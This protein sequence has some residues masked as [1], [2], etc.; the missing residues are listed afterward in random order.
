MR[1]SLVPTSMLTIEEIEKASALLGAQACNERNQGVAV[2]LIVVLGA[3]GS[4]TAGLRRLKLLL[5]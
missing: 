1:G 5:G 2:R 3:T 4:A